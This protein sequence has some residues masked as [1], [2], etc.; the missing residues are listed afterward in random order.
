M[1]VFWVGEYGNIGGDGLIC[2]Y[3][4]SLASLRLDRLITTVNLGQFNSCL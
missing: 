1:F 4:C 2:L 3:L